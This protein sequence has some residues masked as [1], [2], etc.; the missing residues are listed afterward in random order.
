MSIWSRIFG[1]EKNPEYQLGIKYFNQGKYGLAVEQLEKV[2]KELGPHDPVYALGMFYAAESHVHLGKALFHAG[3][4]DA[5]FHHFSIAIKENPT[6]PDL[7][8]SM[9]VIYHRQDKLDESI[10]MLQRAIELNKDYFEAVCYL[11]IVL[12][13]KGEREEADRVFE[14]ALKLGAENPSPISKF[15]SDHLSG[16]ETDIPPLAAIKEII[17]TD[18]DY[19][20][21]VREGIDAYNTGNFEQASRVLREAVNLYPHYAD[22]RFKLGLSLLRWGKYEA[23]REE[24]R[25]ALKINENY[26]EARFYLGVAFLEEKMFKEALPHFEIA[27]SEKPGYADLQCYLGATHFYLGDLK[28]ARESLEKSLELSPLYAKAQYYYGLLLYTL[29]DCHSAVEHLVRGRT[30]EG[31]PSQENL[32]LALVLL[33]EG[34]LEEAMNVLNELLE[35]GEESADILYFI[36][37]V[38]LRMNRTAEAENFFRRSLKINGNF[39]RAREKLALILIRREDYEGAERILDS[40]GDNFADL[41][42]I[43]GDIQFYKENLD[44]AEAYYLKSL[45]V[46]SEY[47]GA[48]VSLALTLRKK[49]RD[50]EALEQLQHLLEFD[51]ENVVARNLLG[52][53]PLDLDPD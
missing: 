3:D 9:G 49:G 35:A 18:S 16:K 27:V 26:T 13:E 4:L 7:Y 46:N 32:S 33:R 41:Y 43:M 29:G 22:L 19:D 28:Q 25:E 53:G 45:E 11:G 40:N 31:K 5:A 37:E 47:G 1:M 34:N 21:Y 52:S 14:R 10:G 6:Y 23:S 20:A 36:G 8:Y 12:F 30:G 51:P 42:K 38:Y 15:L 39:L 50:A 2:V 17:K 24:L 44:Q 48:I